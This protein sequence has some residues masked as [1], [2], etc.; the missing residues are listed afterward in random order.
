MSYRPLNWVVIRVDSL[1]HGTYF[2]LL[3]M[4]NPMSDM[5]WRLNSGITKIDV[6]PEDYL[7][8]GY[9][10]ST[11]ICSRL[12]GHEEVP[13]HFSHLVKALESQGGKIVSIQECIEYLTNEKEKEG[14]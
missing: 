12:E 4:W 13:P 2:K 14:V 7:V 11:Y 5:P 1:V 3:G 10:G 8:H 6:N 9:S